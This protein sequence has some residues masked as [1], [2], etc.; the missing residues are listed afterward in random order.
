MGTFVLKKASNNQFHF[1]L[2]ADNGESILSSELYAA[3]AG[4]QAG[5][6]SV[7]TNATVDAHYERKTA[8]NGQFMFNLKAANH[9][10]IGTSETYT[11]GAARDNG[12]AS[13]KKNAPKATI[14]D[15]T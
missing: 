2:Q 9:E 12:I 4:A 11:T 10:V 7:R 13:V 14:D 6:E 3:K 15:Q 8:Q 1:R 5:I